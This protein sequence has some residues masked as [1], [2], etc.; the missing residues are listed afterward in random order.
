MCCPMCGLHP[1]I[2]IADGVS[3][4]Y[5]VMK[6]KAGLHP[7]SMTTEKSLEKADINL[8]GSCAAI[9]VPSLRKLFQDLT[10]TKVPLWTLDVTD[11]QRQQFPYMIEFFKYYMSL[12]DSKKIT[13]VREL[14]CQIAADDIIFQLVSVSTI[15]LLK[16]FSE[17]KRPAPH[18]P[19]W[20]PA[21]GNMLFAYSDEAYPPVFFRIAGWLPSCTTEIYELVVSYGISSELENSVEEEWDWRVTGCWYS[22]PTIQKRP[23]YTS[24]P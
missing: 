17:S 4:G 3:I 23:K 7:P 20:C 9:C 10:A 8:N 2:V 14:I 13:P 15:P 18:L 6:Q 19:L 5:S 16:S 24:I 1:E 22:G 11:N 21:F 12:T